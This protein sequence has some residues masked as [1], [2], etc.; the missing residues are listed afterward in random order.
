MREF[1]GRMFVIPQIEDNREFLLAVDRRTKETVRR[2]FGLYSEYDWECNT[3]ATVTLSNMIKVLYLNIVG[4][5]TDILGV[6]KEDEEHN[7]FVDFFGLIK[8]MPTHRRNEKAEKT[9]SINCVFYPGKRV[10]DI[11]EDQDSRDDGKID[12]CELETYFLSENENVDKAWDMFDKTVR[13]EL[14]D[15][16]AILLKHHYAAIA[17][18]ECFLEN[19][20]RELILRLV[21]SQEMTCSQ[22]INDYFE[23]N[24]IAS[25]DRNG[26]VGVTFVMQP[27]K[28]GKCNIKSD[29]TTEADED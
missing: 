14:S 19:L 10:N 28:N 7:A 9:G 4:T 21:G 12:K 29:L 17:I 2:K 23:I 26:A 11:I 20:Y 24:A 5:L 16:Y 1:N 18:T 15:K 25:T 3:I 13:N 27:G 8:V 22:N 6:L